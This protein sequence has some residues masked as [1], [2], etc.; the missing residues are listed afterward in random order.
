MLHLQYEIPES[1]ELI[2]YDREVHVDLAGWITV[3]DAGGKERRV[4]RLRTPIRCDL[5]RHEEESLDSLTD[6]TRVGPLVQFEV[7]V[8]PEEQR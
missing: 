2:T 6:P 4:G 3:T 5:Q 8:R 7:R 1:A